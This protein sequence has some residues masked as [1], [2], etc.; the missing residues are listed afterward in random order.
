LSSASALQI[1]KAFKNRDPL[2]KKIKKH[3]AENTSEL[4]KIAVLKK[5]GKAFVVNQSGKKNL[6]GRFD[7]AF[8]DLECF[9]S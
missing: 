2:Y 4:V 9:D 3:F 5:S 1:P 6:Y 7:G 8:Y